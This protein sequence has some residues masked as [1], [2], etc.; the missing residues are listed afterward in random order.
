M[1]TR[2]ATESAAGQRTFTVGGWEVQ[3]LLN[4]I[5]RGDKI[6]RL[7]PKTMQVLVYLAAH[8]GEVVTRQ[9]LEGRVWAGM[10]V[11]YDALTNAIIKLRKAFRDD[12]R[13]PHVIETISKSGYRLI[14]PVNDLPVTHDGANPP[15]KQRKRSRLTGIAIAATLAAVAS[16]LVW[17]QTWQSYTDQTAVAEPG[18]VL[19]DKPTIVVLPFANVSDDPKQEY[20]VDGLTDDLI[21]NLSK[22]SGLFVIARNSAFTYKGRSVRVQQVAK[23]LGVRYVLEG[24]VRRAGDQVRVNA[25][26]IDALNEGHLWARRYDGKLHD[27][28]TLQDNVTQ[29]IVAELAVSLTTEEEAGQ[30][31]I[32]TTS[33]KAYDAFLQGWEHYQRGTRDEYSKAVPFFEQAIRTDPSYRRAHAALAAVYWNSYTNWW[34]EESLGLT[35]FQAYEQLRRSL[36]QSMEQPTALTYQVAAERAAFFKRTPDEALSEAR[37]A[38]ALDR[39]DPAGHLAMATALMKAGR[40]G[41]AAERVRTAMRLDPHYPASYLTRLAQTQFALGQFEEAAATLERAASRNPNDDWT[42][43]YLAATYGH[44]GRETEAKAAIENANTLRAEAGWGALTVLLVRHPRFKWVGDRA[45]LRE[46]LR[47]AGVESGSEWWALITRGSSGTEVKGATTIDV[48]KAKALHNRG[49]P[50]IDVFLHWHQGHIPGARF[51]WLS[52]NIGWE[53][54]EVR[55]GKIVNKNE[56]VVIYTSHFDRKGALNA[57]AV[58]VT[59][60]FQKVYCFPD[61]LASWIAAGYPVEKGG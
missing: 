33:P 61:G 52:E 38:L 51:L 56:E 57:C 23:E 28:F 7:E 45:A 59:W 15:T 6:V 2:A 5:R 29:Q 48:E 20:F 46:G 4:C 54:N 37:R 19:P 21:T 55:L 58:A 47:K 49:V 16:V 34:W 31:H 11:G 24:S 36:K 10:V 25:Q 13:K 30:A 41:D 17:N 14:A 22:I 32:E 26:L 8:P 35:S 53:F 9:T 18:I 27:V 44:L 1:S 43:A 39:N 42:F 3:P 60:G 12:S 40:P 50:F